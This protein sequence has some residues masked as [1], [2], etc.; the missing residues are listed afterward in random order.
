MVY[1]LRNFQGD[2]FFSANLKNLGVLA[3]RTNTKLLL[4][5]AELMAALNNM[6]N[7][8]KT[9]TLFISSEDN[10]AVSFVLKHGVITSCSYGHIQG[11]AALT[12]IQRIQ[13]GSYAFSEKVFFSLAEENNLPSTADIFELLGYEDYEAPAEP[14]MIANNTEITQ[15]YRG[16]AIPQTTSKA[17]ETAAL[18]HRKSRRIYRGQVLEN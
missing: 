3:M 10:R 2:N 9:G 5:F 13:A 17:A 8:S 6:C 11:E 18:A 7:N 4:T 12:Y 15:I 1:F 14:E 16:I